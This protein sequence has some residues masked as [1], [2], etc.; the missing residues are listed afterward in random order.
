MKTKLYKYNYKENQLF[1]SENLKITTL[2]QIIR[3]T[4][5]HIFSTH[6]LTMGRALVRLALSTI[7]PFCVTVYQSPLYLDFR[8]ID[9]Q[10]YFRPKN[11]S[12]LVNHY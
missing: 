1:K 2:C 9:V 6:S 8:I 12:Y 11:L 7:T 3:A 5:C 4:I 10:I